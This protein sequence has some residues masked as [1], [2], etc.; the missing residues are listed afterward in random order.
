MLEGIF[1]LESDALRGGG[2]ELRLWA[3]AA[4]A[5]EA[6]GRRARIVDYIP[7]YHTATG[8]GFAVWPQT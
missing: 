3:V 7:A 1:D 6:V 2:A 8:L 4:G 5:G